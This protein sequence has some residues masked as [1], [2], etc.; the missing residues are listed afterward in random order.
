MKRLSAVFVSIALMLATSMSAFALGIIGDIETG[1]TENNELYVSFES[2]DPSMAYVE[3]GVDGEFAQTAQRTSLTGSHYFVIGGLANDTTY[4]LRVH[5]SNWSGDSYVSD[6]II[7]VTPGLES[8]EALRATTRDGQARI[9][10][11]PVFGGAAYV[12]ERAD[13]ANGPF[14]VLA[15]VEETHYVDNTVTNHEEYRYRVTAVDAEGNQAA[16]PSPVLSVVIEPA[17]FVS[18]FTTDLDWDVWQL[19]DDRPTAK[20]EVKDGQLVWSNMGSD[21]PR[22]YGIVTREPIDMTGVTTVVEV[23]YVHVGAD[24]LNPGFMDQI[25]K[26]SPNEDNDPWWHNGFRMT[27]YNN[28][29]NLQVFDGGDSQFTPP[30]WSISISPPYRLR[31]ELT[32]T[33]GQNFDVAVYINDQ[34]RHQGKLHAGTLNLENMHFYMYVSSIT[35]NATWAIDYLALY[36]K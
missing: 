29:L 24:E 11:N 20:I 32:H 8:P 27:G 12:V 23:G 19:H 25:L 5:L 1:L 34:L 14:T 6:D 13:S 3:F 4:T 7:F 17:I 9:S 30:S 18:D 10:W 35:P 26:T 33:G 31:W 36:Q 2:G 21:V 15:T 22:T 28:T 16:A